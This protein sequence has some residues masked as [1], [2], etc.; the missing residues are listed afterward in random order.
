MK[1][2]KRIREKMDKEDPTYAKLDSPQRRK[3]KTVNRTNI[4]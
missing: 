1:E 3:T 4:Y 2:L